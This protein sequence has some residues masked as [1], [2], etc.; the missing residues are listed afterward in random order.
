MADHLT[1]A[2]HELTYSY[3]DYEA[4]V[5]FVELMWQQ[6]GTSDNSRVL[7]IGCGTGEHMRQFILRGYTCDGFDLDPE[8]V[9]YAKN[10]FK[11]QKIQADVWHD[12]MRRFKTERTYGLAINMLASAN[13]II[14]NDEM[15]SHL[16]SIARSLDQGGIAVLEM[17]HP[18]EYGF[19]ADN[20]LNT[21]EIYGDDFY[22]ECILHFEQEP[23]DS[24]TQT[25]K[26][27]KRVLITRNEQTE[28]HLLHRIQRVYLFQEFKSLVRNAGG[29]ELVSCYG[30]FNPDRLLD[31]SKRSWRMIPILR[32]TGDKIE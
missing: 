10:K 26:T 6:Y 14:T 21:W 11:R 18:R 12:D 20:P 1:P 28:E 13:F 7:D 19:P 15:I 30:T 27:T 5:T 2:L 9:E 22:L 17:F 4:E 29:L 31:N 32:R 16:R 8:M 23:V 3:R 24:V 25:Q